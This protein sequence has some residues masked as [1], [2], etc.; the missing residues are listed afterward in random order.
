MA[1]T[2]TILQPQYVAKFQCIGPACEDSCCIGW[3]VQI[4]KDTYQNYRKCSDDELRSQNGLR[5]LPATGRMLIRQTMPKLC[6]MRMERAPLSMGKSFAP[7]SVSLGEELP[8]SY[9]YN[10]STHK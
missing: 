5:R 8:F 3:R 2:R 6:S 7:S 4:D 9:L 10:L 1:K